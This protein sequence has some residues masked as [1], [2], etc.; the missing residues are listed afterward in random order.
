[1]TPSAGTGTAIVA[2][3]VSDRKVVAGARRASFHPPL[4]TP[5]SPNF[6]AETAR[7]RTHSACEPEG[8]LAAARDRSRV[9]ADG[10]RGRGTSGVD[11]ELER[12]AVDICADL[13]MPTE[14]EFEAPR[15]S[16]G[17]G[18]ARKRSISSAASS[19]VSGK[20]SSHI[21]HRTAASAST[22]RTVGAHPWVGTFTSVK[23]CS[24]HAS[25]PDACRLAL[26][27][28]PDRHGEL[29]RLGGQL[30]GPYRPARSGGPRI[31]PS[32]APAT[33][34]CAQAGTPPARW[35]GAHR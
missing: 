33:T 19:C 8:D 5:A 9:R 12:R 34:S 30:A 18:S 20:R 4:T 15:G 7:R 28:R 22:W 27:V 31:T 2:S 26:R 21:A 3:P 16:A 17:C 29:A 24:R 13:R 1:V 10:P 25:V 32:T 14:A 6:R 35:N 11:D 23:Q